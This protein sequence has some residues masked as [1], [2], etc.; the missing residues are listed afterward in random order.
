[1]PTKRITADCLSSTVQSVSDQDVYIDGEPRQISVNTSMSEE[2]TN[3][4]AFEDHKF[5][6]TVEKTPTNDLSNNQSMESVGVW[7]VLLT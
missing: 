6:E 4:E 1:M 5:Q 3:I 2:I 7:Y